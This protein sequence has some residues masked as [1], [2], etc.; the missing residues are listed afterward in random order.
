MKERL[1]IF[2]FL[3]FLIAICKSQNYLP[4]DT[5]FGNVKNIR[6]KVIF[7]TETENPQLLY[8]N[9]YG[10]SGFMGAE[11][12]ISRFKD[13]WYTSNLCYYINYDRTFN[14][15]GN[16]VHDLWFGKKDDFLNSYKKIYNQK[17]KIVK[18]IDSTNYSTYTT[19]Y[20]YS[21][22]DDINIIRQNTKN[23][24][25]QH[26]YKKYKNDKLKILKEFDENGT[27]DEYNFFYNDKG[28]L[29]YRIYKNPNSWKQEGERSWSYGIQDT[30]L[31]VYKDII[32]VYDNKDRLIKYESFDLYEDNENHEKPL[33]TNQ[34]E[35][36][37]EKG[38]LISIKRRYR[39]G[40]E[41]YDYYKYNKYNQITE[42]H[43]CNEDVKKAM[44]I[45]KYKY[46]NKKISNLE[47]IEEG[48]K[49]N[50][51][52][53]YKF[54]SKNNWIEIIKNVDGIDLFKWTRKI[55]YY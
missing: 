21:D 4:K 20:Y 47:Y 2:I 51:S 49:Y 33:L 15:K 25:F 11:S 1:F 9:D 55:E 31:T 22:Y 18:E 14:Q 8:Y 30:I 12:T 40:M 26:T 10:H 44:I 43:C 29:K 52:F 38:N 50:I 27:V 45:E 39:T 5:I 23:D 54:D 19:N 53:K 41:S 6:E 35:Y 24:Y 3:L 42:R 17:N 46:Q 28:K 48:K 16:I 7:L 13:T 32:N 37:Y 34:V 36:K